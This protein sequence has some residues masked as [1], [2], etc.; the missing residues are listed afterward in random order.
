MEEERKM[1]DR[2]TQMK[3]SINQKLVETGEKERLKD[4]LRQRL[5]ECGWRDELKVCIKC[6]YKVCIYCNKESPELLMVPDFC[7]LRN[8]ESRVHVKSHEARLI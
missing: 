6:V 8:H 4:M 2:S 5:T 7:R 3:N 1:S